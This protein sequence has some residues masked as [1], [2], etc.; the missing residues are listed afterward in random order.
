MQPRELSR[1]SATLALLALTLLATVIRLWGIGFLLPHST[2]LDGSIL[3]AQVGLM[4]SHAADPSADPMWAYYP[5]LLSRIVSLLPDAAALPQ[6]AGLAQHLERAS[7]TIVQIR[8]VVALASVGLVPGTYLLARM[9][10]S[11]G[12]SLCAAGWIA[13]SLLTTSFAQQD[14]PHALAALVALAAVLAAVR[15]RR[16]GRASDWVL[17]GATTSLAVCGLQY[18]VFVLPALALAYWLRERDGERASSWWWL[19]VIVPL[20]V[21]VRVF[22]PFYFVNHF[23]GTTEPLSFSGDEGDVNFN[24]S[25]QWLYLSHFDGSGFP[26]LASALLSYDPVITAAGFLGVATW[27]VQLVR[28][29]TEV[30]V[31]RRRDFL[32]VVAYAVPFAAAIGTYKYSGERFLLPLEPYIAVAGAWGLD[33]TLGAWLRARPESLRRICVPAGVIAL[34]QVPPAVFALKLDAVRAAPDTFEQA[35]AWLASHASPDTDHIVALPYLELPLFTTDEL[36]HSQGSFT[37]WRRYQAEQPAGTIG[38]P[39]WQFE[40]PGTK[41][42]AHATFRADP[43]KHLRELGADYVVIQDVGPGFKRYPMIPKTRDALAASAELVARF[44]P[45]AVDDGGNSKNW[46]HFVQAPWVESFPERM[47]RSSAMGPTLEI[48]KL[49]GEK[50]K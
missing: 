26:V 27:L 47:L 35:S 19:A 42:Q 49:D 10:L 7:H 12:W 28:R 45:L 33:R 23:H 9:F 38:G 46:I 40:L 34:L 6:G 5:H 17:A 11:R 25:G 18:N 1:A 50:S 8:W 24:I 48:Y 13:T 36:A 41:D 2:H 22:Y 4:R 39:R 43:L 3:F 30:D 20:A 44:S 29:K 15:L 37:Y 21:S 16:R 31:Q 14:R 32:V